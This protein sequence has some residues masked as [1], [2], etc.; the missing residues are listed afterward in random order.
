MSS[1]A[2]VKLAE[3]EA[4]IADLTLI[5]DTLLRTIEAG[6]DDPMRCAASAHCPLPFEQLA[7][8][9]QPTVEPDVMTGGSIGRDSG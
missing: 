1:H 6:C 5:R 4:K 3:V 2:Q 9:A 7:S 8:G